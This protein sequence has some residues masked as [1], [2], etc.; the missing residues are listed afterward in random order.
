MLLI[1]DCLFNF[2]FHRFHNSL[3]L[4][5]KHQVTQVLFQ[6]QMTNIIQCKEE[7]CLHNKSEWEDKKKPQVF[8]FFVMH[9][10][11]IKSQQPCHQFRRYFCS[12]INQICLTI[13]LYRPYLKNVRLVSSSF[14]T[15]LVQKQNK[16]KRST[17]CLRR[18]CLSKNSVI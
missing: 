9:L 10:H 13:K 18:Y 16:L 7:L 8:L 15:L 3:L 2:Q 6:L 11:A 12:K 14:P 5:L 4:P 1:R 17:T